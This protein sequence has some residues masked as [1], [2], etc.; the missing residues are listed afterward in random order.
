MYHLAFADLLYPTSHICANMF[1]CDASPHT[2][3][4]NSCVRGIISIYI[5]IVK[6]RRDTRTH[7]CAHGNLCAICD[8]QQPPAS[9]REA[10]VYTRH[11][12]TF[13][14]IRALVREPTALGKRGI[15][16]FTPGLIGERR[17]RVEFN[18][19]ISRRRR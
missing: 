15:G 9:R 14:R 13:A 12:R 18:R 1:K 16:Q 6:E 3:V 2:L 10:R 5:S 19:L 7:A 4:G 17:G 8:Q 11:M